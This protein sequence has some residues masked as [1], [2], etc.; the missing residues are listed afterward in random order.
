MV[1]V[2]SDQECMYPR[3]SSVFSSLLGSVF[4]NEND[5]GTGYIIENLGQYISK[6]GFSSTKLQ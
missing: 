3:A 6:V 4:L 1:F 2:D 5:R